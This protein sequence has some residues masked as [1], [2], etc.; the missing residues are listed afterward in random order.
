MSNNRIFLFDS[1][2]RDGAQTLGVNFSAVDKANIATD[3]DTLGI[4]Y[5][6]G[7]WPGANPTDDNFFSNQPTLSNAKLTAFGMTR[8]SGRSTD[9]DPGLRALSDAKTEAVCIVGKTWDFHTK[10]A[11]GV[12]DSE[13][14]EMISDSVKYMCDQSKEVIFDAEHFFDGFKSNRDFA[15]KCL[16]AAADSGARWITL[17]DTNGGALPHEIEEIVIDIIKYVPGK[18]L[19]IHCHD[20]TGNAVANSIAAVRAGVRQVQ[21]TLNGLGERCGN[22]NLISLIPT[23]ILKM[24]FETGTKPEGMKKLTDISRSLDEKMNVTSNRA[25]P[26]VGQRAFVHKGGLHVSAVEKDPRTYEHVDPELIGNNRQIVVSDQAGRSNVIAMFRAIG[27]DIDEKNPKIED[28]IETIKEREHR[29]YAYDGADASFEILARRAL[30]EIPNYYKL[31]SFRVIDERR[32]NARNELVTISEATIKASVG[33]S[34]IMNVSEGNGPVNAL[35]RALREVLLPYYPELSDLRLVDYKVRILTPSDATGAV[36]RVLIESSD[37]AGNCWSTV[38]VS[39][40]IIDASYEAL[41]D[42]IIYKLYRDKA[43]PLSNP[44]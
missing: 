35:D 44:K 36:T 39:A 14:I 4:D 3:L 19:G 43:E 5:I 40:N 33:E 41:R 18:N 27:L 17:C 26:Y 23:L 7:G 29:G 20:D 6:E 38:G 42:S 37:E 1:T 12:D 32:W 21:G 16:V 2:L 24:G 30:S 31:N 34:E 25:A 15:I 13:N 22:A 28:L 11:L 10:I 8:R 9:N